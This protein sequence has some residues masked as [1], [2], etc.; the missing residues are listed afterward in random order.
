MDNSE[1]NFKNA[2]SYFLLGLDALNDENYEN[3]EEYFLESLKLIPD[4]VS[5]L[6][7]LSATQIKLKKFQCA[8]KN[9]S[10]AVE[11]EQG[12]PED[13]VNLGLANHYLKNLDEAL[14]HFDKAIELKP[15]DAAAWLNKGSTL[16]DLK[17]YVE[18]LAHYDK[19]IQFKP[20]YAVAYYNRGN[21]LRDLKRLNEALAS[22]EKALALHPGYAEAYNNRGNALR[23]LK[24]LN[25][26]LASYEK[27][28]AL[29]P[30][31]A[32]A[33]NNRGNALKDLKRLGE[34]LTSYDKALALKPDYAES[35]SN[36]GNALKDLKRLDEALASYDK[37]LELK[38][39]LEFLAGTRLHV[40]M[41]LCDWAGFSGEVDMLVKG[42]HEA[43]PVT[44]PFEL[45]A[46]IDSPELHLKASQIF[47]DEK[48]KKQDA[49]GPI[50]QRVPDGK[51]RIGYYS[52]DFRNHA[53]MS[54]MAGLFE[55]HDRSRFDIYGFSFGPDTGDEMRKRVA[56]AFDHFIDVR[57]MSDCEVAKLSRE[58]G[59]DIA[60]NRAGYTED[61][62]T[63]IFAE[64]AAPIQINYLAYPGTM[65]VDYID[66]VIV[67]RM[68]I[69]MER[70][71][72]FTEKVVYLPHS[73]QA[74]DSKR[75]I[76][77]RQFTRQELGLPENEF[78]FCCFNNNY[79]ILPATFDGWM[80]ILKAVDGSVLWLLEE[81][82]TASANLC[83][84]AEQRGVDSSRLVF[85]KRMP[86]DEHLARHRHANL[87]ID[88]LPY[89]AHT[90]T[91]DAL[92]AGLPVL[93]C[94]GNSFASRVAASLLNAI[95]LP[96]LITHTH[97]EY[98]A[99]A[100][101]LATNPDKL[102]EIKNKLDRNR[103]TTPLFDTKLF[104]K[105]IEA[106][107]E[108]MYARYRAGLPPDVIEVMRF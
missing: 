92:W 37:A 77:D 27:A 34:A 71:A 2:K 57:A 75:K 52:A 1:S 36:R 3:A 93:T 88:T 84:E 39:D 89:N 63:G 24:R 19:A 38:F 41:K 13:W 83:K 29:H 85:A 50:A 26:A 22:Y 81:S 35:Y 32:E 11:L 66:Y 101:E 73:Y 97:E 79:K 64:R 15:D 33:Y 62:R 72:D 4:R 98:E 80:R 107:Y 56:A 105:H 70:Q 60:V 44:Q 25:E 87:F 90:T 67:D 43:K 31:Y 99:K 8:L 53:G 95:D 54:L 102:R 48:F 108:A 96:E 69:P 28:L 58:L 46:L 106:A 40:K 5:T 49:L 21:A 86:S 91:S 14:A 61:S 17:R 65:G 18:A 7:N 55:L 23:D 94:M 30:G 20:D 68:V 6:T 82:P 51:M 59:I 42:V 9:S 104:T 10:K 74:N 45:L 76:S 12:N 78:T 16:S 103:L 47:A 100:I